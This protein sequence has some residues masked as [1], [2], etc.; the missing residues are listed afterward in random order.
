[1]HSISEWDEQHRTGG[2]VPGSCL[3]VSLRNLVR[4]EL[5]RPGRAQGDGAAGLSA[6]RAQALCEEVL[7]VRARAGLQGLVAGS[8]GHCECLRAGR[9]GGDQ[10]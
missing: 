4:G 6:G 7:G 1:M 5:S 9:A 10:E 3:T 2:R 8:E